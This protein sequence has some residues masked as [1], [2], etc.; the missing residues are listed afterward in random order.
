MSLRETFRGFDSNVLFNFSG[1]TFEMIFLPTQKLFLRVFNDEKKALRNWESYFHSRTESTQRWKK[2]SLLETRSSQ[3]NYIW[4]EI[5]NSHW[6]CFELIL[7]VRKIRSTS[8]KLY[9]KRAKIFAFLHKYV[10]LFPGDECLLH[11]DIVT[12]KR[13]PEQKLQSKPRE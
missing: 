11:L 13:F 3:L 7:S 4:Q 1:S 9:S 5:L 6:V 2:S 12:D 8:L 10:K